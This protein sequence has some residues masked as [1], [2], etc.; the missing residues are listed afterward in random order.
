LN[1]AMV[2]GFSQKQGNILAIVATSKLRGNK[3]D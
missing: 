1:L 2:Q 3:F